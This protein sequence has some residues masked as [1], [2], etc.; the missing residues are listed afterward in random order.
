MPNALLGH[1]HHHIRVVMPPPGLPAVRV[2]VAARGEGIGHQVLGLGED[3]CRSAAL[4]PRLKLAEPVLLPLKEIVHRGLGV[5]DAHPVEDHEQRGPHVRDDGD[6]EAGTPQHA[7]Q[8]GGQLNEEREGH[9]LP[10]LRHCA[11]PQD[12]GAGEPAEVVGEECHVGGLH[13]HGG[14]GHAHGHAQPRGRERGGVVHAVAHHG[15]RVLLAPPGEGLDR[16]Q[17]VLRGE[18]REGVLRS[19]ADV[20]GDLSG[21]PG[22]VARDHAHLDPEPLESGQ[23]LRGLRAHCVGARINSD[24]DIVH[25]NPPHGRA[26]LLPR[27]HLRQRRQARGGVVAVDPPALARHAV[28]AHVHAVPLHLGRSALTRKD[29]EV[30]DVLGELHP[31]GGGVRGDGGRERV[32]GLAL[33]RRHPREELLLRDPGAERAHLVHAEDA[34][35]QGARL[36]ERDVGHV[37]Q[38]LEVRAALDKHTVARGLR[39]AGDVGDGRGDDERAGAGDDQQHEGE[40]QV[41]LVV[42]EPEGE[43]Q[44]REE[45]RRQHHRGRVVLGEVLHELLGGGPLRLRLLHQ[46]H[47]ARHGGVRADGGGADLQV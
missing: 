32:D 14:A 22:V 17:F 5:Q 29:L 7:Q 15:H 13:G 8:H 21:G 10:D 39:E 23:R 12:H 1:H 4:L 16:R 40:M 42:A 36:V 44:K 19:D 33:H 43:G 41:V 20:A 11:P 28:V 34:L 24:D 37:A 2:A 18:V 38:G 25:A 26:L 3:I 30:L 31:A 47:H 45:P 35:G 9:V 46:A 6:P 27:R